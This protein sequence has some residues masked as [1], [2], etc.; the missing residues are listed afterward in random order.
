MKLSLFGLELLNYMGVTHV[1]VYN[2]SYLVVP[3]ILG[4]YQCLDNILNDY[5]E[6]CWGHSALF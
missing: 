2:D 1:K 4:K 6:R 5:L 3:Q